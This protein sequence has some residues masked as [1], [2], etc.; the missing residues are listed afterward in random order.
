MKYLCIFR[1]AVQ[2]SQ[3]QHTAP[4]PPEARQ[5]AA[6]RWPCGPF[7]WAGASLGQWSGPR[8][9]AV[10]PEGPSL[11]LAH[12]Y[13]KGGRPRVP[14]KQGAWEALWKESDPCVKC[15][16]YFPRKVKTSLTAPPRYSVRPAGLVWEHF[17]PLLPMR[18]Y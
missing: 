13:F 7:L 4:K 3:F 12:A 9:K 16:E 18:I 11:P 10:G 8:P 5:P 1:S 2:T 15:P 6:D 17:S 14:R